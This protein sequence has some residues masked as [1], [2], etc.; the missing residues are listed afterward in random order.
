M[1]NIQYIMVTNWELHWDKL[2]AKWSNS[3]LY[4][5]PMIKNNLINATWPTEAET[6]FIKRSKENV[7]EKAW[8]GISRNFR[9]DNY[10]GKE[11]VRFDV[12]DLT[13]IDC[14]PQYK[15]YPSGW[16]SNNEKT[17]VG[18]LLH[19]EEGNKSKYLHPPFFEAMETCDSVSFELNCF[20]LLRLLGIHEIHKFPQDNNRGKADGFFNFH[21]LSVIYDATLET[22]YL[23]KKETQI[24][25]YINQLRKEEISFD[26]ISYNIRDKQKQVW[27]ITRG[28]EVRL[29]K[30]KD[31][32]RVKEVPYI[33]LI[34][35][36]DKR[37]SDEINSDDL[38]DMLKDL[39]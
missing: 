9:K 21:S 3:T 25:N 38:W 33:K 14:P 1:K 7:F 30:R 8:I 17:S 2:G 5:Y 31:T 36:Y 12:S 32:I 16:Y 15:S 6:L 23:N 34:E 4:T 22:H 28:S 39:N 26:S 24:E 29:V 13:L 37:M 18:L 11:A 27:I 19:D 20:Y 10:N 35:V